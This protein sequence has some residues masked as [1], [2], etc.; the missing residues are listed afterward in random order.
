M[1][2]SKASW[3]F[4]GA[5]LNL[6]REIWRSQ[7][8]KQKGTLP[9]RRRTATN[10]DELR[11]TATF[12]LTGFHQPTTSLSPIRNPP[13]L[14][15][16]CMC[17]PVGMYQHQMPDG[18]GSHIILIFIHW[19]WNVSLYTVSTI[20]LVSISNCQYHPISLKILINLPNDFSPQPLSQPLSLPSS[21]PSTIPSHPRLVLR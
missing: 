17:I 18:N 14:P 21:I 20:M 11:R 4:F 3:I 13:H 1:S 7:E 10:C 12:V 2:T 5:H 8:E 15:T 16:P 19:G 6:L 9:R